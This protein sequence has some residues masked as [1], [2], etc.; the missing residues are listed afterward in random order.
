MAGF[1]QVA[2]L[3]QGRRRGT[4]SDRDSTRPQSLPVYYS[5]GQKRNFKLNLEVW[6]SDHGAINRGDTSLAL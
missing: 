3:R 4:D 5:A 2:L 6:P 1:A